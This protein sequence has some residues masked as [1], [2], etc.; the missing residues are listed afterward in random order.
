MQDN[1][2]NHYVEN[3]SDFCRNNL[4]CYST[5][6]INKHIKKCKEYSKYIHLVHTDEEMYIF[7]NYGNKST[8]AYDYTTWV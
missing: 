3:Y 8:H 4:D 2:I 7:Q 1:S 5:I 6:H